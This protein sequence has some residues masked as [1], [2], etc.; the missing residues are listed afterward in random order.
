MYCRL[1]VVIAISCLFAAL[2]AECADRQI[3]SAVEATTPPIIDADLSDQCW[4]AASSIKDFYISDSSDKASEQTTAWICYDQSNVYVAFSCKDSQPNKIKNEQKKRR[5]SI[6]NDDRV[7]III[8]TFNCQNWDR[9]QWFLV[10]AGGTQ[11]EKLQAGG[12]GKIEWRGDWQAKS[13]IL[14]DGYIVEM[15]IPFSILQYDSKSNKMGLC[16]RR[17]HS[18]TSKW[19]DSPNLNNN[20]GPEKYYLWDGLTLPAI[21]RKPLFMGYTLLGTGDN[22]DQFKIGLDIKNSFSPKFTGLL[23]INPD[24]SNVEQQ[25]ENVSHSYNE[26]HLSDNRPFFQEGMSYFPSSDIFYTRRINRI[27]YGAK[28]LFRTGS[29]DLGVMRVD[30]S[31]GIDCNMFKISRDL[32]GKGKAA[33]SAVQS[34]INN[35]NGFAAQ[36]SGDYQL[37]K[38]DKKILSIY[39]NTGTSK[40][41][42]LSRTGMR[43]EIASSYSG[44]PKRPE[45]SL[46]YAN[47][48]K[49]Y[50][51]HIGLFPENNIKT[52]GGNLSMFDNTTKGKIDFW[53]T[54]IGI[55]LSNHQDGTLYHNDYSYN[56][57][58][59]NKNGTGIA[60]GYNYSHRPPYKDNG[61]YLG[62][63]WGGKTLFKGGNFSINKGNTAGGKSFG[64]AAG[65]GWNITDKLN[66]GAG[67]EYSRIDKPSPSAHSIGLLV[68]NAAYDIDDERT[69]S[70]RLVKRGSDLNVYFAYGQRSRK[71][72]DIYLTVGDPNSNETKNTISVKLLRVL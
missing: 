13:K 17:M 1:V 45:I 19:W 44:G 43:Y 29:Y 34:N 5:G 41:S 53:R 20:G 62:Y 30:S 69:V 6:G 21:K 23:S 27:D 60:F 66:I 2:N 35:F 4:T 57:Y 26:R 7:Q 70:G 24:F 61:I 40:T 68:A 14:S 65:Q 10:S 3:I 32:N 50:Q 12:A 9:I 64:W 8:D 42:N 49:Y 71:G 25:V 39:G 33:I 54:S 38:K 59:G 55:N 36:L 72:M 16:F 51:P 58:I 46:Y 15:A 28:L 18:R 37:Y 48:D 52:V 22:N 67:Y 11:K 47:I 31:D 63:S 56:A